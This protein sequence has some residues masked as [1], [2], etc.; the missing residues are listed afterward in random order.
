M[1]QDVRHVE[2]Q[3]IWRRSNNLFPLS[4]GYEDCTCLRHHI[5]LVLLL[6]LFDQEFGHA[7]GVFLAGIVQR[8]ASV[9]VETSHLGAFADKYFHDL[10]VLVSCRKMQRSHFLMILR[11]QNNN[12]MGKIGVIQ[13]TVNKCTRVIYY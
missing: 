10:F 5:R 3:N 13:K 12:V 6:G 4:R 9:V 8:R 1:C 7:D 2:K 11:L